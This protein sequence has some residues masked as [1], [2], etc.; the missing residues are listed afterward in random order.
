[1]AVVQRVSRWFA[2]TASPPWSGGTAFGAYSIWV[3]THGET[4][5]IFRYNVSA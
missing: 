5:D 3:L 4:K 1:M 2:R